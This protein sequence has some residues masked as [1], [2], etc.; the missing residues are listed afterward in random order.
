MAAKLTWLGDSLM[1]GVFRAVEVRRFGPKWHGYR[2]PAT[3]INFVSVETDEDAKQDAESEVR[4]LL[5]EAGVE[6]E[7]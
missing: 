2:A 7:P 1:L 4:R 6:V 5:K 3:A